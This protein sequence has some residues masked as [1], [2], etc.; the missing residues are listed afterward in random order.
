MDAKSA[1]LFVSSLVAGVVASQGSVSDESRGWAYGVAAISEYISSDQVEEQ[2]V[3]EGTCETCKGTG[4][5]GDGRVS[6]DCLDCGGDGVIDD[7]K[8]SAPEPQEECGPSG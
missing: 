6:T 3:P 1:L 5:V 2:E 4:K 8:P 7:E